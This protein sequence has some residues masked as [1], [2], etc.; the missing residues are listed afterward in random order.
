VSLLYVSHFESRIHRSHAHL[1]CLFLTPSQQGF[2]FSPSSFSSNRVLVHT[3]NTALSTFSTS[4]HFAIFSTYSR[5]VQ[6][7]GLLFSASIADTALST[8]SSASYTGEEVVASIALDAWNASA[9]AQLRLNAV[10]PH[11]S[12][13]ERI[14][15]CEL[16]IKLGAPGVL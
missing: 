14:E 9:V 7:S 3:S 4:S 10:D 16:S 12:A 6:C 13:A 5:L 2:P 15:L 11:L 8:R 1:T